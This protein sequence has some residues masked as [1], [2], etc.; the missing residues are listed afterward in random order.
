MIEVRLVPTKETD[1]PLHF[2]QPSIFLRGRPQPRPRI[3]RSSL[4]MSARVAERGT[5]RSIPATCS[6]SSRRGLRRIDH[7]QRQALLLLKGG[8]HLL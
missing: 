2:G 5:L 6:S 7:R 8:D 1:Q 4:E 3:L